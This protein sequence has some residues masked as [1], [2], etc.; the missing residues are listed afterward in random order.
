MSVVREVAKNFIRPYVER[1]DSLES[2]LQGHLGHGG[3]DYHAQIGGVVM[4]NGK[5]K[6]VGD[7]RIAITEVQGVAYFETY[8]LEKLFKEVQRELKQ[9]NAPNQLSLF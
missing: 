3:P 5:Q 1:G 9:K 4:W 7:D 8:P 2:L 6:T